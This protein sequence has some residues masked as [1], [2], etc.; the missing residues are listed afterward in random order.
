MPRTHQ[1]RE[2]IVVAVGPWF[3]REE[4]FEQLLH[5][6]ECSE[7]DRSERIGGEVRSR[8]RS[9]TTGGDFTSSCI[10]TE[11]THEHNGR[12][13]VYGGSA[14]NATDRSAACN[15][16]KETPRRSVSRRCSTL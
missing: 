11:V 5:R 1:L 7:V 13:N 9:E 15:R 6:R 16:A 14:P 4:T 12:P 2:R 8:G 10:A 3:V